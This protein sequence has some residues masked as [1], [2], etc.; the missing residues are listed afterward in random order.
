MDIR[1]IDKLLAELPF[2]EGMNPAFI[3]SLGGCASNVRFRARDVLFRE[4]EPANHFYILESGRIALDISCAGRG[5]VTIETIGAGKVVGW[6]WLFPPY[7][8]SYGA[9]AVEDVK[10]ISL[11]GRCLRDKCEQDPALG[12]DLMKRFSQ[13]MLRRMQRA[14]MQTLDIYGK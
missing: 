2:F 11:D 9:R 6:S 10:A 13:I 3:E 8:W 14:R 4:N 1:T 7:Q 5:A 12:Y